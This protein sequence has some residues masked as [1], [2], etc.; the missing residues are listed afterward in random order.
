MIEPLPDEIAHYWTKNEDTIVTGNPSI[1][2]RRLID[3]V[4]LVRFNQ[5]QTWLQGK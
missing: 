2:Q 5:R 4:G 3:A 1:D